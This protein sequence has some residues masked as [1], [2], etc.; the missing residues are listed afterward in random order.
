MAKNSYLSGIGGWL[1]LLIVGLM[2]LGP[3]IGFGRLSNEFR[4]SLERYPQLAQSSEWRTYE[5]ASWLI[6]AVTVAIGISAGYRLWKIH[7]PDSVRF[8]I[9]ALWLIGPVT[10]ILYFLP[11]VILFG[12]QAAAK[13]LPEAIGSF[14][15]SCIVAG[16]WTAYLTR[17]V[18]V[19][20]TYKT[21]QPVT[22]RSQSATNPGSYGTGLHQSWWRRRSKGFRLWVFTSII[23]AV[24]VVLYVIA[25]EPYGSYISDGELFKTFFV[26]I[27][28]PILVGGAS[29]AYV[30]WVR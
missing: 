28:P 12:S 25:F 29:Y 30:K 7:A 21:W 8:A 13:A 15:A 6:F 11:L 18:R 23:W 19:G 3:L 14:V 9:L 20:N 5:Q 22:V 24:C 10:T 4:D 2:A 16:I 1:T 17:S 26:M 27:V